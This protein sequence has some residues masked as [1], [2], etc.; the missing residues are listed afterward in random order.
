[1]LQRNR[2][3]KAGSPYLSKDINPRGK[4]DFLIANKPVE[5]HAIGILTKQVSYDDIVKMCIN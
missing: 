5:L 3:F 1:L 4:G 2:F